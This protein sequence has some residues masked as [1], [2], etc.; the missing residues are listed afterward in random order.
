MRSR[1]IGE[2]GDGQRAVGRW[3]PEPYLFGLSLNNDLNAY[4]FRPEAKMIP[5]SQLH[6]PLPVNKRIRRN[7]TSLYGLNE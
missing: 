4:S 1:G 5:Y 7:V 6:R 2:A 3:F